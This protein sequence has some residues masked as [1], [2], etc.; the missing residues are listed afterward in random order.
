MNR[1]KTGDS[2]RTG[3][4]LVA[5]AMVVGGCNLGFGGLFGPD[6]GTTGVDAIDHN[7]ATLSSE[8]VA[9]AAAVTIYL[10]HASVGGNISSGLDDLETADS[11]YDRSN[12]VFFNRGNPGW[13]QKIDG[14]AANLNASTPSPDDYDAVT[15]KYC[16]I[17]TGADFA[18]YR[19]VMLD[20]E[21]D[22]PDTI[23]V[24]WTMP[25]Q[26]SGSSARDAFN[27]A[28]RTYCEANDKLLFDIAD[29]E[30][31]DPDGNAITQGGYEAMWDDYSSDGGHLS[32]AGRQRVARAFW[33]LA[34][35]ISQR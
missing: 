17:D 16:Y 23:F 6:G 24:W 5:C 26:T 29:I 31:H 7:F 22:F 35:E 9:E 30:S 13:Q 33:H 1:R 2:A 21:N 10:E 34:Y 8:Q 11:S 4:L 15:M 25:L 20:L 12:L 27:A 32:V 19:D 28:V 14:F 18:Y 3:I